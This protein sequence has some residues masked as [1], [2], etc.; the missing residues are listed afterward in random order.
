[1]S[2][3]AH[4]HTSITVFNPNKHLIGVDVVLL[5]DMI[6]LL[7]LTPVDSCFDMILLE[8]KPV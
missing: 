7:V 1:M 5:L 2:S 8:Q 3:L 4:D 6:I